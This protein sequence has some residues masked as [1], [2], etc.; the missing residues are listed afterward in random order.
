M[1]GS[2]CRRRVFLPPHSS[3]PSSWMLVALDS[4]GQTKRSNDDATSARKDWETV[5]ELENKSSKLI[6]KCSVLVIPKCSVLVLSLLWSQKIP[7]TKA[8]CGQKGFIHSS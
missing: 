3:F 8:T 6:P 1:A 7:A 2:Y 5:S 4:A